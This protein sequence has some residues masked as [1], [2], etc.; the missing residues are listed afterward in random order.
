MYVPQ[1]YAFC[2]SLEVLFRGKYSNTFRHAALMDY[3]HYVGLIFL[4]LVSTR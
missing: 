1:L 2:V 3:V 4:G